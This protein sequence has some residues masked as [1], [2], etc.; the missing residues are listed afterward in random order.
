MTTRAFALV[1]PILCCALSFAGEP[2][3][4]FARVEIQ[5]KLAL[6]TDTAKGKTASYKVTIGTGKDATLF[7]LILREDTDLKTAKELEGKIVLVTGDLAIK[8]V[9]DFT[10]RSGTQLLVGEIRVKTLKP[11]TPK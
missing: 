4:E 1:G 3:P 9:M 5:G 6:R 2:A 8:T 10:K 7:H 11:A